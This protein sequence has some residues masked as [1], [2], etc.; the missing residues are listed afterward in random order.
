MAFTD[1]KTYIETKI[2][3]SDVFESET[4]VTQQKA[5]TNAEE[6]LYFSFPRY[7]REDKPLPVEAIAYQTIWILSKD[8]SIRKAE[9]GVAS[10]SIDGMTQTFTKGDKTIAPEVNRIL[11]KRRTG[12]YKPQV[13]YDDRGYLV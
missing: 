12:Y 13:V 11:K 3:N 6:I 9:L 4:E 8:D 2:L 7:S 1:V 5:V 10:Q